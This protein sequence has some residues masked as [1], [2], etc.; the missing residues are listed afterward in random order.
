M[1]GY[2]CIITGSED[3]FSAVKAVDLFPQK[4]WMFYRCMI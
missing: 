2:G 1:V 4:R 3:D